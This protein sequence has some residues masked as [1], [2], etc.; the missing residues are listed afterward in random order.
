MATRVPYSLFTVRHDA[1]HSSMPD[2]FLSYS[3]GDFAFAKRIAIVLRKAGIFCWLDAEQLLP[4]SDW[5]HALNEALDRCGIVVLVASRASLASPYC[6]S[7]WRRALAAGKPVILAGIEQIV[8]P[9]ELRGQPAVD[10]RVGGSEMWQ[11]LI[12]TVNGEHLDAP[13]LAELRL[14]RLMLIV[15]VGLALLFVFQVWALVET[16]D[17]IRESLRRLQPAVIA[18]VTAHVALLVA[19]I[20]YTT[21]WSWR[22]VQ[23]ERTMVG[24]HKVSL[25][26]FLWVLHSIFAGS[27]ETLAIAFWGGVAMMMSVFLLPWDARGGLM[28]EL[29]WMP[30]GRTP[31]RRTRLPFALSGGAE[32]ARPAR[33]VVPGGQLAYELWCAVQDQ[34]IGERVS[35]A[36]AA[37]GHYPARH[38]GEA[39]VRLLVLSNATSVT[40]EPLLELGRSRMP[41][42]CILA[43]A[44]AVS[45]ERAV[46]HRYQWIDYRKRDDAVLYALALWLCER[47]RRVGQEFA[48]E[49][50]VGRIMLPLGGVMMSGCLTIFAGMFLFAILVPILESSFQ[51][52][53][54]PPTWGLFG[55][56]AAALTAAAG[57]A[58]I[59]ARAATFAEFLG[60]YVVTAGFAY[61]I[62]LACEGELYPFLALG[63]CSVLV[64][65]RRELSEWLLARRLPWWNYPTIAPQ[66]VGRFVSRQIAVALGAAAAASVVYASGEALRVLGL[67]AAS[68]PW[69]V[70]GTR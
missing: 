52:Y 59:R 19:W 58:V 47:Q 13:S 51:P 57:A 46:F 10:T 38:A 42:V 55:G 24:L 34:H 27:K 67:G 23:R 68:T 26:P 35:R 22:F 25:I 5:S 16:I 7:E 18:L 56:L 28:T 70:T 48:A 32:S 31:Q 1:H 8:V 60:L 66:P 6:A 4:G 40:F 61:V 54:G 15:G 64:D 11:R 30:P 41:T 65:S 20:A 44:I 33:S 37:R 3:R 45:D 12:R 69:L 2:V 14:P 9:D 62:N 49:A 29:S 50:E 36:L 53:D 39:S 21:W 17:Y 63:A 43:S